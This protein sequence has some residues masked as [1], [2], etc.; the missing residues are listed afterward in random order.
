MPSR[1]GHAELPCAPISLWLFAAAGQNRRHATCAT[2]GVHVVGPTGWSSERDST[3]ATSRVRRSVCGVRWPRLAQLM[4]VDQPRPEP[5]LRR[6]AR[7][8]PPAGLDRRSRSPQARRTRPGRGGCRHRSRGEPAASPPNSPH[9]P[10]RADL[11]RIPYRRDEVLGM[12]SPLYESSPVGDYRPDRSSGQ[13]AATLCPAHDIGQPRAGKGE[14]P[15]VVLAEVG[16]VHGGVGES[17]LHPGTES[18]ARPQVAWQSDETDAGFQ[19]WIVKTPGSVDH[20]HDSVGEIPSRSM[21]ERTTI[22]ASRGLRCVS[23]TAETDDGAG[24]LTAL[25]SSDPLG[26]SLIP[27]PFR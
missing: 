26:R 15:D 14:E 21:R 4:F 23:T 6:R 2:R 24:R 18:T 3:N 12:G 27:S 16:P 13:L 9:R 25:T 19:C 5:T 17:H 7:R 20:H 11:G 1:E 8:I 22:E 10:G